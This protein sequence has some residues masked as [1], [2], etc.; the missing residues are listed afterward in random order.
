MFAKVTME[1]MRVVSYCFWFL[2]PHLPVHHAGLQLRLVQQGVITAVGLPGNFSPIT[3]P[4]IWTAQ[5]RDDPMTWQTCKI[6]FIVPYTK[7]LWQHLLKLQCL[8]DSQWSESLWS[9]EVFYSY[10]SKVHHKILNQMGNFAA[11]HYCFVVPGTSHIFLIN[12]FFSFPCL[13]FNVISLEITTAFC[14]KHLINTPGF[15]FNIIKCTNEFH[16]YE[17]I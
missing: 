8:C 12:C 11:R 17:V 16:L 10:I 15:N 5:A 13:Y 14:I 4:V 2:V 3:G 1:K 6:F 9:F 7:F